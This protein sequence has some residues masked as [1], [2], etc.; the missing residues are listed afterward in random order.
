M[1]LFLNWARQQRSV[2]FKLLSLALGAALFLVLAPLVLFWIGAYIDPLLAFLWS[3]LA[4]V[5][6]IAVSLPAGLAIIFWVTIVQW[7]VGLGTPAPIAPTQKLISTGPYALC[8]N[9]LQL[10]AVLYYLGAGSF[11]FTIQRG[12]ACALL[13]LVLGG[14]YHK[15]IEERE[16]LARFGDDYLRYRKRTPFIVPDLLRLIAK[17]H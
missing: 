17:D 16:L 14:L 3:P 13:A 12:L 5:L 15:F 7:R 8:R 4:T 6:A 1:F 10:G 9:P 2:L 11:F